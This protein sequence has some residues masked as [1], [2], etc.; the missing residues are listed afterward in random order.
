MCVLLRI[1]FGSEGKFICSF[2]LKKAV[3][4]RKIEDDEMNLIRISSMI[5]EFTT[6]ICRDFLREGDMRLKFLE[7]YWDANEDED[8]TEDCL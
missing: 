4:L 5:N 7:P 1:E 3:F 8:T 6:M 2:Q